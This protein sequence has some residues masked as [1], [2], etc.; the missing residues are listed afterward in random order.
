[1]LRAIHLRHQLVA[2]LLPRRVLVRYAR[3]QPIDP[4]DAP[5][6]QSVRVVVFQPVGQVLRLGDAVNRRLP[7]HPVNLP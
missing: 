3:H 1:M 2:Q 7:V 6:Q 4:R 5:V